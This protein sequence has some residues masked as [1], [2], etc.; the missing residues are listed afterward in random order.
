MRFNYHK[1]SIASAKIFLF[2]S[3][4]SN[5]YL[6]FFTV[7]NRFHL[8]AADVKHL[9]SKAEIW[10]A[11]AF[12]QLSSGYSHLPLISVIEYI[13]CEN[14]SVKEAHSVLCK[15]CFFSGSLYSNSKIMN[16]YKFQK[17]INLI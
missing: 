9:I 7:W 11:S 1:F 16:N 3:T 14:S 6:A 5:E 8:W 10:L 4:S 13:Y 15:C 2:N 17:L 12:M